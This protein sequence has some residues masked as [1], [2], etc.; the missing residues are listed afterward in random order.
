MVFFRTTIISKNFLKT[1]FPSIIYKKNFHTS[2]LNKN[3]QLLQINRS[4]SKKRLLLQHFEKKIFIRNTHYINPL[5]FSL[6]K[7]LKPLFTSETLQDLYEYQASLIEDLNKL[8][9]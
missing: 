6:E 5:P 9:G 2:I 3:S 1:N 4:R 7:G 8:T